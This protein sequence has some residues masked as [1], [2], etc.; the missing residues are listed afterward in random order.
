MTENEEKIQ[1]IAKYVCDRLAGS[2][3]IHRYD[4]YSTNSVYLKF[5]YGVANSLRISDHPG[6]KYLSYRYNII[7]NQ[8]KQKKDTYGKYPQYYY[9]P[10]LVDKVIKDI[11]DGKAIKKR[12]Y[13]DYDRIVRE[14]K[15]QITHERG[16][17]SGARL[18][19]KNAP[20]RAE[21][22]QP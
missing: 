4:A 3:V 2:V 14:K 20:E 10:T 22:I 13:K 17:W 6:K 19:L 21:E 9:P 16:F 12:K 8:K 5:D 18:W 15:L 11:L 7:L 1:Q